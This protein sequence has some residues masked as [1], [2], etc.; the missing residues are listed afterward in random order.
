MEKKNLSDDELLKEMLLNQ[1]KIIPNDKKLQYADL[2]RICKYIKT[3]IFEVEECCLWDGYITNENQNNK[4]TYINFYFRGKKIALHRLLFINYI[5]E[6]EDDEYLKFLC[7]NKG[8]CCNVHHLRKFR[9]HPKLE[10]E[11][12]PKKEEKPVVI[13][14][15][16]QQE[17]VKPKMPTPPIV[18]NFD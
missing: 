16:V 11:L 3:S 5:G 2:K 7:E 9:Y 4:G 15:P 14:K 18:I 6:L 10:V 12:V 13:P 17:P 8:M 1:L